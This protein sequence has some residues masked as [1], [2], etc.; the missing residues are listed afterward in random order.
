MKAAFKNDRNQHEETKTVGRKARTQN[1]VN[2]PTISCGGCG[3][4]FR[5][6][7]GLLSKSVSLIKLYDAEVGQSSHHLPTA[8]SLCVFS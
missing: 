6:N 4:L 2:P 8:W 1:P 5:A 3:R 7:I